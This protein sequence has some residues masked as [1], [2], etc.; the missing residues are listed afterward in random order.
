VKAVAHVRRRLVKYLGVERTEE[1]SA[2]AAEHGL[3]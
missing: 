3:K 1:F 2:I